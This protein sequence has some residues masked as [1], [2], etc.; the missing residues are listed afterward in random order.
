MNYSRLGLAALGG[1][2]RIPTYR[3]NDDCYANWNRRNFYSDSGCRHNFRNDTSGRIG[4][5]G[6]CAHRRSHWHFRGLQCAAQ[7]REPEHRSET[8]SGAGCGLLRPVDHHRVVIVLFTNPSLHHNDSRP[9]FPV[10]LA[11]Q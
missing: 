7:L 3:R 8:R 2:V 4:H 9:L 5:Y 11:N 10:L 1:T 6:R